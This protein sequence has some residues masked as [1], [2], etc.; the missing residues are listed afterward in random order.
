MMT[1]PPE[2]QCL[3]AWDDR[4]PSRGVGWYE[5]AH[6]RHYRSWA[7]RLW[8]SADAVRRP[9]LDL[10]GAAVSESVCAGFCCPGRFDDSQRRPQTGFARF[11]RRCCAWN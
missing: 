11:R 6:C 5:E 8:V 4:G 3:T 7:K 1:L 9:A 10:R 2:G